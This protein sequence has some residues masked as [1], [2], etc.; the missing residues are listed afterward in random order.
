[1]TMSDLVNDY[2]TLF[3]IKNNV[4]NVSYVI[5]MM[6]FKYLTF[7]FRRQQVGVHLVN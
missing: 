2:F 6:N 1:M 4:H 7:I 3:T 5:T